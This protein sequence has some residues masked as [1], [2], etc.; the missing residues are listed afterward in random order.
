[1]QT[2]Y[3]VP[4]EMKSL[5]HWILWR[6]ETDEKGKQTKI[7]YSANYEGR[8]STTN[9][10]T[11]TSYENAKKKFDESR[12]SG[13]G[14]VFTKDIGI[15][16][17]DLDHVIEGEEIN[18]I[19]QN[20]VGAFNDTY[21]ELSQ[22]GTGIH[23]FAKGSI[24][25]AVKKAQIELYDNARYVA[26]TGNSLNCF[27]LVDKQ[28]EIDILFNKYADK[29]VEKVVTRI[30]PLYLNETEIIEKIMLSKQAGKF[31]YYFNGS[32]EPNSENTLA[33]AS[34][35][36]FWCANDVATIKSIMYKS[37]LVRK[38]FERR[39]AGR[40]WLDYVIDKAVRS[41]TEVYNPTVKNEYIV[42]E[43][44][45]Q[46]IIELE[47]KESDKKLYYTFN[48]YGYD[49]SSK[50]RLL[51]GIKQLDY[52]LK[53]FEY[54]CVSLWTSATNGGKT[55]MMTMIIR[56]TIKQGQKVFMFNGE[57][58]KEDFKNNLYKQ[59]VT[60]DNIYDVKYKETNIH[61]YYVKDTVLDELKELYGDNVILFDNEN[62][63]D[64]NTLLYAMN[65][66]HE[67]YG[68]RM[69]VL[70]NL[71]QIDIS[72]TNNIYLEQTEL[73]ERLRTFSVNKK[74][75]INLVAHPKKDA[76]N[77][78]RPTIYSVSG[79]MN[80]TNKAFN[81]C[82]LIRKDHLDK[83]G[84]EYKSLKKYLLSNRYDINA[85]DEIIEVMKTKGEYC[86][87]IGLRYDSLRKTYI[88]LERLTETQAI[89]L[90]KE[91]K[92]ARQWQTPFDD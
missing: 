86:G 79:S 27:E 22:S 87:V 66:V 55:T 11:W 88:E 83:D 89:E 69:F 6:L 42:R 51:T 37:E 74:V 84:K 26:F 33:L 54:G 38:K 49:T 32:A 34:I 61:D 75:H 29:I 46:D 68:V 57:Q 85:C 45:Q 63:R 72:N 58:T 71:M 36:A 56:E 80:I 41:T 7:P 78:I 20:I 43:V 23:I 8:A 25:R 13:L 4:E 10:T 18:N 39:T 52:M 77:L 65:E 19:A 30:E 64:I 59:S 67:L 31:H 16:F 70:D 35:L 12:Y 47:M 44:S 28:K 81:V 82:S 50:E 48:D 3:F 15:T 40:T 76:D 53:G 5:N 73:M 21:I 17:I 9:S 92:E 62:K 24:E 91:E 14:F 90:K 2:N 1:M 60:S